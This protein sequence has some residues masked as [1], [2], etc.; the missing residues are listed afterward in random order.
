MTNQLDRMEA[1]LDQLLT[2]ELPAVLST[3]EAGKLLGCNTPS[4][5]S[6]KLRQLGIPKIGFGQYRRSDIM[7]H[8]ARQSLAHAKQREDDKA[9]EVSTEGHLRRRPVNHHE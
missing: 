5:A 8:L 3:S 7:N 2:K 1:K 9:L 6:H 4:S